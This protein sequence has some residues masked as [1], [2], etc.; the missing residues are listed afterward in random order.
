MLFRQPIKKRQHSAIKTTQVRKLTVLLIPIIYLVTDG[1]NHEGTFWG[2]S[3]PVNAFSFNEAAV[4]MV[5]KD[6][7]GRWES[8]LKPRLQRLD[9]TAVL[10]AVVT[11][12]DWKFIEHTFICL[13]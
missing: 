7:E 10:F 1:I 3:F 5:E 8:V 13:M 4:D 9:L 6:L 12:G 11:E 2:I